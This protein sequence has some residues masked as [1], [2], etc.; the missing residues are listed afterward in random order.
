MDVALNVNA[1][2]GVLANDFDDDI[3]G[4]TVSSSDATSAQGFAVSVNAD[5]SFT[6]S[7]TGGFTGSDTFSYT[8]QDSDGYTD[9][10]VVTINVQ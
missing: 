3:P 8:T 5:G 2:S 10:G 9:T 7:P 1:A 6:Y 4:L